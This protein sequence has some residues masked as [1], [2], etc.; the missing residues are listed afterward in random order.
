M[1]SARSGQLN[2]ISCIGMEETI[3]TPRKE[4][5]IIIIIN[6]DIAVIIAK[7]MTP[8]VFMKQAVGFA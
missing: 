1:H 2:A 3:T 8:S 7:R 4:N 5:R 6:N